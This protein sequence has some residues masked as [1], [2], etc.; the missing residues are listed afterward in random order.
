MR[1]PH[2]KT[3]VVLL[4]TLMGAA[5]ACS[6]GDGTDGPTVEVALSDFELTVAPDSIAPGAV[7]FAA[8]NEGPT[9]HEFEIF[10]GAQDVDLDALPIEDDVADTGG[11]TL[12]DEV[13]DVTPGSTAELSVTLDPGTY[14]IVCNLPEHYAQG[15]H[16]TLEVAEA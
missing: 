10:S 15:M 14:A 4:A 8:S 3:L 7:T 2:T 9:T 11:L 1:D 13:E 6:G 16:A 5:V 12:V